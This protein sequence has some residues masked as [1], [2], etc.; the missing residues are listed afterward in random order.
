MTQEKRVPKFLT[1]A[2]VIGL[3]ACGICDKQLGDE[4]M[5]R[6]NA[7]EKLVA[8]LVALTDYLSAMG[9]NKLLEL[10]QIKEA[11]REAGEA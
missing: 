9:H 8:A 10:P 6:Y 11:L 5:R 2:D 3:V 1:E 4:I 7:H